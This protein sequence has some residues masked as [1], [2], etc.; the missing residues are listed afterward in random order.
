MN[1]IAE[2]IYVETNY[3]GVNVGTIVTRKGLI[4]IDTP[5]FPRDARNWSTRVHQIHPYAVEYL[6]L[7][8]FHGDRILNSRWLNAAIITHQITEEKLNSYDKRYPQS[9]LDSLIARNP[10]CGRELTSSPVEQPALSFEHDLTIG[11][12]RRMITLLH[13][14]GPTS[15]TIWVHLPND[16]VLFTSDSVVSQQHPLLA[17]A[18][19]RQWLDSLNELLHDPRFAGVE[20]IIPGRGPA[21]DLSS[22]FPIID[23]LNEMRQ[24]VHAHLQAGNPREQ[25][26]PGNIAR[27]L[28]QFPLNQWPRDW[29]EKQIRLSLEHLYDELKSEAAHQPE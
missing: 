12:G 16:G 26:S 13:R 11:Y 15:A 6:V 19:S 2:K 9:L 24:T 3:P 27:F 10:D 18:N 8:D 23:Y 21:G 22:V 20:T 25:V 7:S 5:S 4:C 14:P 17:Q 29:V 28:H 1:Q